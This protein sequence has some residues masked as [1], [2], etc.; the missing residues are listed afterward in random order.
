MIAIVRIY[1]L[2]VVQ[3]GSIKV[4]LVTLSQFR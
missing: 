3:F 1:I 4:M 2:V